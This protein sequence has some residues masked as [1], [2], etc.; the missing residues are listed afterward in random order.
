MLIPNVSLETA[1]PYKDF[2]TAR[3]LVDGSGVFFLMLAEGPLGF[4]AFAAC[5]TLEITRIWFFAL[6][7]LPKSSKVCT[8][9]RSVGTAVAATGDLE[10]RRKVP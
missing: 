5:R 7:F 4:D 1:F 8:I 6:A 3:A 10:L 9:A 2:R